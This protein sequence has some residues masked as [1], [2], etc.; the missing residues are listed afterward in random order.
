MEL[1]SI[2]EEHSMELSGIIVETE[3]RREYP[4]GE[5][6]FHVLGYMSE[7]PE[8]QFDSLRQQGYF[9]GDLIGK[10]GVE[11]RCEPVFRGVYGREY[12]EVNAYGKSLG[13]ISSIP[14][15]DPI[16]GNDVYLSPFPTRSEAP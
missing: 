7:I 6:A 15:I 9:Y 1:V 11:R 3:S 14:R 12:I 10:S 13:P 2:I 8:E 4:L 16:P 5:S